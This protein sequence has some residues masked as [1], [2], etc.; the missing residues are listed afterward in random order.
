[1]AITYATLFNTGP[2]VWQQNVAK[3]AVLSTVT[4]QVA[5]PLTLVSTPEHDDLRRNGSATFS[6]MVSAQASIIDA[7]LAF[8]QSSWMPYAARYIRDQ[9]TYWDAITTDQGIFAR[10]LI[11]A[12]LTDAQTIDA[13][14]PSVAAPVKAYNSQGNGT[15]S[16]AVNSDTAT[17]KELLLE[18]HVECECISAGFSIQNAERWVL[19]WR[20]KDPR[21][22]ATITRTSASRNGAQAFTTGIRYFDVQATAY[23]GTGIS[24]SARDIIPQRGG[25]IHTGLNILI[26]APTY[27]PTEGSG[28]ADSVMTA[29]SVNLIDGA[30]SNLTRRNVTY[31]YDT[32]NAAFGTFYLRIVKDGSNYNFTWYQDSGFLVA[33]TNTITL[34]TAAGTATQTWTVA[35]TNPESTTLGGQLPVGANF[36]SATVAAG[37]LTQSATVTYTANLPWAVGDKWVAEATNTY[38]GIYQRFFVEE[39]GYALPSNAAGGETIADPTA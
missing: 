39:M 6:A 5:W 4:A 16:M 15:I 36:C 35:A 1:M 14:A 2:L 24:P 20:G 12:M 23:P 9:E 34:T 29:V 31:L 10:F 11:S 38:A 37:S 18:G 3:A 28:D 21:T 22:G 32:T 27:T 25:A 30:K 13:S 7:A 33:L 8:H 19:R 26:S 17:L